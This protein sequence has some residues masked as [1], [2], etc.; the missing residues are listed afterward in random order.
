V[1]LGTLWAGAPLAF[2][3]G[4]VPALLA[5]VFLGMMAAHFT[6][7]WVDVVR[8]GD[9]TPGDFPLLF[10]DSTGLLSDREHAALAAAFAAACAAATV[11]V[12][13]AAG[14]V[15]ALLLAAALALALAYS[16]LLDRTMGGLTL[17]Y[18]AGALAVLTASYLAAGG[19]LDLRFLWLASAV[20]AALI[21]TKVRADVVDAESDLKLGKRSVAAVFGTRAAERA[22][23]ALALVGL[24]AAAAT[25]ALFAAPPAFA[26]PP[27]GAAAAFAATLR[28][29]P[30]KAALWM[31]YALVACLALEAAVLALA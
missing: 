9:R 14:A 29:Q 4:P 26:L 17:G 6:D 5:C 7:S 30:L 25:P 8:R 1:A 19:P 27:A 22:G 21:G 23:L 28:A 11:P 31:S 10:R 13:W 18:P 20:A 3:A 12:A 16:P 15:P 2:A 24:A